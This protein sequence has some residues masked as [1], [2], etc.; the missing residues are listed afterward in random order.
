MFNGNLRQL[1]TMMVLAAA[2]SGA[3]TVATQ[4]ESPLVSLLPKPPISRR[5]P[6][7][8]EGERVRRMG[9]ILCGTLR[10]ENGL[11]RDGQLVSRPNGSIQVRRP[12]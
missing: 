9:Q 1:F 4:M 3:R 5:Y 6:R 7:C 2:G 12:Y 10:Q 8:S 11:V